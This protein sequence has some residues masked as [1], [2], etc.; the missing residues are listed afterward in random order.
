MLDRNLLKPKMVNLPSPTTTPD[1]DVIADVLF[2]QIMSVMGL[3]RSN[4]ISR[5]LFLLLNTPVKRMSGMLVELDQNIAQNGC[6]L[7]AKELMRYFIT[8]VDL[9]GAEN[10]PECGPLL[11]M[12]NHPAAYD[13]IIL[14]A[15]IRR[16]NLKILGSDIE[17]IKKLPNIANLIIP[18]PYHIPSR[19]QTVRASI[20][21][22]KQGGA[23]L[24]FPRGNVEPDPAVSPGAE[25]SLNGWSASLELFLR[26][27]PQT[28]SVVAIASGVLSEK[29]FKNPLIK[30]WKKYEQRQKVAEIFQI[31][32]QLITGRK[33]TSTPVVSFSLPLTIN[34]LGG[35][36]AP[37]GTLLASLVE[38]ARKLL[39]D[40]PHR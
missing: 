3:K 23:L 29:W 28:I 26:K 22:L 32:T 11:L 16:D 36:S 31:A 17:F 1:V 7:A 35:E 25:E 38:Q 19:L 37:E 10:I 24:I 18:V 34:D 8:D 33:T 20:Q 9:R 5:V 39:V 15:S 21:H 27:V 13:A 14:A 30:L 4:I 40:H 2:S 6:N 12:C